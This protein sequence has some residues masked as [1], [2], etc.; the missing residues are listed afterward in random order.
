MEGF[1][2]VAPAGAADGMSLVLG[3]RPNDLELQEAGAEARPFAES[4]G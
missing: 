1:N 3:L 2:V 4:S